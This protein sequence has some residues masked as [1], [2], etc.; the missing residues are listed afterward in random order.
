VVL[1]N[2]VSRIHKFIGTKSTEVNGSAGSKNRKSMLKGYRVLFG[3]A[4][5]KTTGNV[6]YTLRLFNA[7]ELYTLK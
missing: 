3:M 5:K 1:F 4:R 7:T 6:G 2:V